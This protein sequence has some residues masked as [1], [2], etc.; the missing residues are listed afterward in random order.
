MRKREWLN[1]L[2]YLLT[3]HQDVMVTTPDWQFREFLLLKAQ[4]KEKRPTTSDMLLLV[5]IYSCCVKPIRLTFFSG[6][7]K[8]KL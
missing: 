3:G 6:T 5:I 8:E 1:W 4:K 2:L 7:E